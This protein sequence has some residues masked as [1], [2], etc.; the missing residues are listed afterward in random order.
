MYVYLGKYINRHKESLKLKRI[1]EYCKTQVGSHEDNLELPQIE[2]EIKYS[3]IS[4]VTEETKSIVSGDSDLPP[5]A[6]LQQSADP[7]KP[8]QELK[9]EIKEVKVEDKEPPAEQPVEPPASPVTIIVEETKSVSRKKSAK[10]PV[11]KSKPNKEASPLDL[12]EVLNK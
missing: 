12:L 5:P 6:D 4:E 7:S 8:V 3:D 10:K 2:K 1:E 11:R 9:K